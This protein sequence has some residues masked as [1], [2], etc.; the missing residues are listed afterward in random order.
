MPTADRACR[1]AS[2]KISTMRSEKPLITFGWSVKSSA[3]CTMPRTLTTRFTRSRVPTDVAH[4]REEVE[5]R[6]ARGLLTLLDGQLATDLAL[7]GDPPIPQRAMARGEE[8]I[9]RPGGRHV[10]PERPWRRR[11]LDAQSLHARFS[12]HRDSLLVGDVW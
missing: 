1:P 12:T 11:E 7:V 8:E 2:P 4:G 5:S 6:E 3:H 10:A 9:A